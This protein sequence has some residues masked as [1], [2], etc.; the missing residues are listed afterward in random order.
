MKIVVEFNNAL[1]MKDFAE[2][3]ARPVQEPIQSDTHLHACK[4]LEI[5]LDEVSAGRYGDAIR[6]V[7]ERTGWPL[8][9]AKDWVDAMKNGFIHIAKERGE[10]K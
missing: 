1:E 4:T 5:I 3:L 10:V 8:K 6:V 2:D 7:R 9:E